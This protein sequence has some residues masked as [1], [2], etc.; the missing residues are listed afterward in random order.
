[1][2]SLRRIGLSVLALALSASLLF[3]V[4]ASAAVLDSDYVGGVRVGGRPDLRAG[5]PDLYVPS[6]MLTTM[7]GRELWARDPE[8]RRAMASTTKIMTAVVVLEHSNLASDVVVDKTASSVGQSTMGLK[9]G[10]RMTIGEL[11]KGVLVQSGN[12]AATLIAEKVGG[13]VPAFVAMMNAKA[14]QLDLINTHYAN[15]HGLDAPGHYTSAE[16]LTALARYAMRYPQFRQAVGTYR[17]NVVTNRY[18]HFLQSHN[19]LLKTYKGCEGIKTGWTNNAGYCVVVAA[20]R[21][22][23]EL[24]GT[25]MGA[26]SEAGRAVQAKKLLDWGF[27]HYKPQAVVTAGEKLGRVRVSDYLERTVGAES[28]ETTALPV[29]DL[30]GPVHRRIDLDPSVPAPVTKGEKIGTMTVFQ[31]TTMIAQVPVVASASIPVPSLWQQIQFFF[32]RVWRGIFG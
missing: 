3:T 2:T 23:V 9:V 11:L 30:A 18:T 24:V 22:D 17:V 20:K 28:G 7:D 29:F 4:P 12:D 5:A 10:E 8:S 14:K 1:M 27:A 6:G 15:P 31:G 32:A 16:D 21:G 19:V 25:I 26:A 13:T